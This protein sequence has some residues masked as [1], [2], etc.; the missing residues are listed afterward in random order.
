[1]KCFSLTTSDETVVQVFNVVQ[2]NATFSVICGKDSGD[3]SMR[4]DDWRRWEDE[5]LLD[6]GRDVLHVLSIY[7][8]KLQIRQLGECIEVLQMSGF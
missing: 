2:A 8:Q 3:F 4:R 1:M 7:K 5:G 6:E